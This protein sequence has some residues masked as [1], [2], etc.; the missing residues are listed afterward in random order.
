MSIHPVCNMILL[1]ILQWQDS[2]RGSLKFISDI[3][4]LSILEKQNHKSL[5]EYKGDQD[6][7]LLL[8]YLEYIDGLV[9]ERHN[10]IANALELRLSCTNPS[11][12]LICIEPSN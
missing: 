2:D 5:A 4:L 10:S 7:T 12:Y 6:V 3:S 8:T 11:N 1:Q 9:Q